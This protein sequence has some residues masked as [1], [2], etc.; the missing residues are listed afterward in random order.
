MRL[1]KL[2]WTL[3]ALSVSWAVNANP[4]INSNVTSS[5]AAPAVAST[6]MVAGQA[7]ARLDGTAL[8]GSHL[9]GRDTHLVRESTTGSMD[10]SMSRGWLMLLVTV[11]LIGHQ[12][13][14]K[15][16]FLRPQRFSDL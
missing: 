7:Q 9:S 6:Q 4:A 16:R 2:A 14:R 15:H 1:I 8:G 13:R 3:A 12:L 5:I 10:D 11:L